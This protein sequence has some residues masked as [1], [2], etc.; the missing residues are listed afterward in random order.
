MAGISVTNSLIP[1]PIRYSLA[2]S[3]EKFQKDLFDRRCDRTTS[4]HLSVVEGC[5]KKQSKNPVGKPEDLRDGPVTEQK[6]FVLV[7]V[8][9]PHLCAVISQPPLMCVSY[10]LLQ[11]S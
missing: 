11:F 5:A 3:A 7:M 6:I 4:Q 2:G 10:P 8:G 1:N 9:I